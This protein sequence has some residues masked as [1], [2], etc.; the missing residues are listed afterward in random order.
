[1]LSNIEF[2]G[3]PFF[4]K[5]FILK[6]LFKIHLKFKLKNKIKEGVFTDIESLGSPLDKNCAF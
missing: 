6:N 5:W 2:I 1:M 4:E 3:A